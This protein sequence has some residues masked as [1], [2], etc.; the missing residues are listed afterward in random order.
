MIKITEGDQNLS[1]Q[2][3]EWADEHTPNAIVERDAHY[4][5]HQVLSSPCLDQIVAA[6]G[7]YITTASGRRLLDFHGNSVHQL[8]FAHPS[9][10]EAIER[11][12]RTL[13]YCTRRYTNDRAVELAELLVTTAPGS[14]KDNAR[15]LLTPSGSAAV[16]IALKIAFACTGC[17][18]VIAFN[19]AFHGATLD[20][21][22]LSGQEL[23]RN[24]MGPMLPGVAHVPPP[25]DESS[26]DRIVS[27]LK[28]DR[29]A[30]VIA[31]PIRATTVRFA[32][33]H[34]WRR[35]HEACDQ[36]GTLLIFDEIPT[37]LGRSGMLWASEHTG[38][39]P[40]LMVIGKGLGGGIFPQAAVIGRDGLNDTGP[41]PVC[42]L[43]L[44]HYTH[45]KSP[46]GAAAAIA[47]INTI[48]GG[49]LV[50]RANLLGSRWKSMYADRLL[51]LPGVREVRQLGLMLAVELADP[52]H[53][54]RA[55]YESLRKG[56]SFKVGGGKTLVLFPPLN[57]EIALLD[58]ASETLIDAIT[59]TANQ[60]SH[61]ND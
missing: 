40:D 16:G 1:E 21:A 19:D 37:A 20:A 59:H 2:R 23:F 44:G 49:Q 17:H 29:Y 35:I 5:Y 8:G 48:L 33:Q 57:I 13:S 25:S 43:A 47:T 14:L 10:I 36:T 7:P 22:S 60:P 58:Q 31:E 28:E 4:Y 15:V 34:A 50:E 42:Q 12:M 45:E 46:V 18:R 30:A 9:V 3:A 11:Q 24:G 53:A 51:A 32:G 38:I 27:M 61:A 26:I 54:D 39:T 52:E 41:T 6:E 56:L 55:M